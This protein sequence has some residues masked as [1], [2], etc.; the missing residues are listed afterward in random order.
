MGL[1]FGSIGRGDAVDDGLCLLVADLLVVV[2]DVAKMVAT[3][4]VGFAHRHGVVRQVDIAVIAE[5]LWHLDGCAQMIKETVDG[6]LQARHAV[7]CSG[8]SAGGVAR[9]DASCSGRQL[10]VA[11]EEESAAT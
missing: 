2:D 4:V 7:R 10:R 1:P 6:E 8:S 9:T 11:M 5:E 3:T